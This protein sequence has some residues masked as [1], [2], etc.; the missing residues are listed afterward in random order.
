MLKNKAGHSRSRKKS[1]KNNS[2]PL[3]FNCF[4][5]LADVTAV[6]AALPLGSDYIGRD[7]RITRRQIAWSYQAAT[8]KAALWQVLGFGS[9][10]KQRG[11]SRWSRS[12]ECTDIPCCSFEAEGVFGVDSPDGSPRD[13]VFAKNVVHS[14]S[15]W[16]HSDSGVPKQ[17]PGK[18]AEPEVDPNALSHRTQGI[19]GKRR[20]PKGRKGNS[21]HSHYFA[22]ARS[23]F[24]IHQLSL[25]H[26]RA[27]S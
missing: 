17:Q 18:I 25:T 4:D 12:P 16:L 1:E 19:Y 27:V 20:Y 22:G 6:S 9:A 11:V 3:D 13:K 2:Q 7:T 8:N 26:P 21:C 15:I 24:G 5:D 10:G 14:H 23:Q